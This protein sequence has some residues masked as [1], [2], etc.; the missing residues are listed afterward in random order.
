MVISTKQKERCLAKTIEE[1][2][3]VIQEEL[4]DNVLAAIWVF[5]WIE[6]L[7]GKVI[8]KLY[9]QKSVAQLAF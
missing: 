4:I 9:L 3:L 8:S 6:I 7:F 2:S 1:L 5:K